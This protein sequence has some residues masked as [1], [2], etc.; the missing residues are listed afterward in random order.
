MSNNNLGLSAQ[1]ILRENLQSILDNPDSNLVL[2]FTEDE[3]LFINDKNGVQHRISSLAFFES[4]DKIPENEI[5][6][7]KK[8]Y[9]FTK[10]VLSLN[11]YDGKEF[12][13]VT[14]SNLDALNEISDK[15]TEL[16]EKTKEFED[17]FADIEKSNLTKTY[18]INVPLGN[19]SVGRSK[20]S[21]NIASLIFNDKQ[22]VSLKTVDVI[23]RG[24][25]D[26]SDIEFDLSLNETKIASFTIDKTNEHLKRIVTGFEDLTEGF[27][28]IDFTILTNVSNV[29]LNLTYELE[30]VEEEIITQP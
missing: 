20:T 22:S 1:R 25:E 30:R 27:I 18:K 10:P 5:L 14:S 16:D 12:K 2:S 19:L 29:S 24:L 7:D 11:T 8:L 21:F 9:I 17:K 6:S 28:D 13:D 3:T 23:A 26:D 4:K 15:V